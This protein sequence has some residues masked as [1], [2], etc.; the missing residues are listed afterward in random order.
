MSTIESS[1]KYTFGALNNYIPFSGYHEAKPTEIRAKLDALTQEFNLD[2][3]EVYISHV[4]PRENTL[5]KDAANKEQLIQQLNEWN[6]K[7]IHCSYWAEPSDFLAK[8]DYPGL[9]KRFGSEEDIEQYFGDLTG[10]HMLNRW[11]QEYD[12]ARSIGAEAVT[13][14]LIDYFHIDGEWQFSNTREQ[15]IDAMVTVT[16][17]FL[18]ELE[19]KALLDKKSP[20]IELE[21]A[22]FGLEFGVQRADDFAYIFGAVKDP[23]KKL[24]IAWD[25]NHLLH[26]IG[27]DE[28]TKRGRFSLQESEITRE[29]NIL[30]DKYGHN[31]YLFA[32]KWI[33]YNLLNPLIIDKVTTIHLSDNTLKTEEY[34]RNGQLT[35]LYLDKL[36]TITSPIDKEEFGVGIV[37]NYYDSHEPLGVTL[38]N[39][40]ATFKKLLK[41]GKLRTILHELKNNELDEIA[42]KQQITALGK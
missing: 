30:E 39:F 28:G 29:M 4:I 37:L 8:V 24:R 36:R 34:F 13:F 2:G 38:K 18:D 22:G 25:I 41:Y 15:I 7:K 14:H 21:N 9:L 1:N 19:K 20:L 17:K 11:A 12:I 23:H 32:E 5:Y 33:E 6:T 27:I 42:L 26:A 16:Q 31:A 10:E 3:V 35:S 40:P